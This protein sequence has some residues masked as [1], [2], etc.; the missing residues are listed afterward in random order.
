VQISGGVTMRDL[1]VKARIDKEMTMNLIERFEPLI[2]KCF[3]MY[4]RDFNF[5]DDAMQEGY[6]TVIKCIALYDTES[7]TEFPGY[8]KTA[9][10]NNLRNF[11]KKIKYDLSID[12]EVNEYS[13]AFTDILQSDVNIE[14][15]SIINAEIL[16]MEK[17]LKKL[18]E[19]QR[20]IIEAFYFKNLTLQEISK[21]RRCH[22][23]AVARLKSRALIAL[24]NSLQEY[25][26]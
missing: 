22:Y 2:K 24:Q 9:V 25:K 18:T 11:S 17:A 26:N 20:E 1:V 16:A 8:V 4:V 23:M 21:R 10:I 14:A 15:E 5:F 19:K 12:A 13:C 7:K 6:L 3:K